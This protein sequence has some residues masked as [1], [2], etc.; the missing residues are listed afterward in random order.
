MK[1]QLLSSFSNLI[2][3][4]GTKVFQHNI[5]SMNI[6]YLTVHQSNRRDFIDWDYLKKLHRRNQQSIL[7]I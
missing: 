4:Y 2:D 7:F 5:T 6:G 3:N 1:T